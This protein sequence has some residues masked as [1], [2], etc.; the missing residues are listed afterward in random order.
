[1]CKNKDF[2]Q[3]YKIVVKRKKYKENIDFIYIY[4]YIHELMLQ[5]LVFLDIEK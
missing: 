2:R 3:N 4:Y 1:M 5:K